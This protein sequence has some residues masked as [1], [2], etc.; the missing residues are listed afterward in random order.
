MDY[1]KLADK[2]YMQ[3]VKELVASCPSKEDKLKAARQMINDW[4][5]FIMVWGAEDKEV[6]NE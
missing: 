4:M 3:G 5:D 2:I 1:I 6:S